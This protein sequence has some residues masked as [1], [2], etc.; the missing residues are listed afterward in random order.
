MEIPKAFN[1]ATAAAIGGGSIT[2]GN[3]AL[4]NVIAQVRCNHGIFALR[5]DVFEHR[6]AKASDAPAFL[7]PNGVEP[8]KMLAP[9]I[10]ASPP[11]AGKGVTCVAGGVDSRAA[12]AAFKMLGPAGG[13]RRRSYSG[14][15]GQKTGSSPT[16][17]AH[18]SL[19]AFRG[20]VRLPFNWSNGH[21]RDRAAAS[22]HRADPFINNPLR[23]PSGQGRVIDAG[24]E[25]QCTRRKGRSAAKASAR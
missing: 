7:A 8:L 6:R 2:Q 13:S 20:H 10:T 1:C 14:G 4:S 9:A 15:K 3:D 12:S 24:T 17:V 5:L 11:I 19:A 23:A 16:M 18:R 21:M 22:Y 25:T